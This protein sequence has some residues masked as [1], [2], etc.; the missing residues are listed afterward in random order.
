MTSRDLIVA[1]LRRWYVVLV[2]A[3]PGVW[4]FSLFG[5]L[6]A[7]SLRVLQGQPALVTEDGIVFRMRGEPGEK[8]AFSLT[9]E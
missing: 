2:G 9:V 1:G 5:S 4:R 6:K 8:V 7:G 3:G